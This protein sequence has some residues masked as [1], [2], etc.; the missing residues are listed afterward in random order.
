MDVLN[1]SVRKTKEKQQTSKVRRLELGWQWA[2]LR[3]ETL[4]PGPG[5]AATR[6]SSLFRPIQ[7]VGMKA[8]P[9]SCPTFP[10]SSSSPPIPASNDEIYS[11]PRPSKQGS[12]GELGINS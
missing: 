4:V 10:S 8:I 1:S 9:I 11:H 5:P 6:T 3:V 7:H 12:S 2:G